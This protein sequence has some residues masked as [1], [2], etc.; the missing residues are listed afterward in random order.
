MKKRFTVHGMGCSACAAAIE[1][2][3]IK[4]AGVESAS[5]SLV[6]EFLDIEY[7]EGVIEN[8]QIRAVVKKLGYTLLDDTVE[9]EVKAQDKKWS[10]DKIL[11]VRFLLSAVFLLALMYFSM[12]GMV[13]LP[14]PSTTVSGVLQWVLSSVI[15]GI[16]FRFFT[17]GAK[18][19]I[20]LSPNMDTLVSLGSAVSYLYSAVLVVLG[21]G[22]VYTGVSHLYF[23]SAATILTL[24]TLGKWLETLSKKRT[25][26]E[27]DKLTRLMPAT[28]NLVLPDGATKKTSVKSLTV[29]DILLVRQGDFVPVD[30]EIVKGEG[31][32]DTSAI[33]GE[34]LP[35]AV[36]AGDI[37]NSTN[38]VTDGVIEVKAQA[39]GEKTSLSQIIDL[40]KEAGASKAPLQKL[41]DKVAAIFVPT[42]TLLAVVTFLIWFFIS[43]DVSTAINYGVSV[44]VISC[45]CSLGLA[46]PVAI[47]VASGKGASM[48]I[49]FKNAEAMQKVAKIDCAL[50][51]KTATLTE[52]KPQVVDFLCYADEVEVK[53]VAGGI[54]RL[55]SQPLAKCIYEFCGETCEVTSFQS[56][57]G[58]GVTAQHAGKTYRLGN[59]KFCEVSEEFTA[60]GV[61][62]AEGKT[63]VYMTEGEKLL[64]VFAIAD[65]IKDNAKDT[66]TSLKERGVLVGM[67]T[68]D[69]AQAASAVAKQLGIERYYAQTLPSEKLLRV[70]EAQDEGRFV[71]MVGDGVNDSPALKQADVGVAV[72]T[73]TD[74]AIETAEVVLAN[75][76]VSKLGDMISLGKRTVRIIKQNLFWAF[77]YNVVAIPVAAGALAATGVTLNPMIA[78]ACMSASSLFVV[79]NALRLRLFKPQNKPQKREERANEK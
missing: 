74:V 50:L 34:S 29:G 35:R 21:M 73:G 72:G 47:M 58:G 24:V 36:K 19:V 49:L 62:F 42:V 55:S 10:E 60:D 26:D 52:G 3:L 75:G 18:A 31:Y 12:G 63:V 14:Q 25:G 17:V 54:E 61:F 13:G 43:G 20:N 64:A 5:V 11:L 9:E 77:F 22:G 37:I 45:P 23:E 68:G 53:R 48:G 56:V 7:D 27:I 39:V 28:A 71:A 2:T 32:V 38:V 4:Q 40:V 41:A 78:A 70:K 6:G 51:D 30:G 69:N 8:S 65:R 1:R 44:L 33:T 67:I 59:K 66:V 76:D 79:G 46:T 16:N 57:L 15:I